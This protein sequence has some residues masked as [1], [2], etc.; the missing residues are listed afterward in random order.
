[1]LLAVAL[2]V[3]VAAGLLT[4]VAIPASALTYLGVAILAALESGLA[5]VRAGLDGTFDDRTFFLGFVT[6]TL[7]A[8]FI[9]YVGVSIGV[10][11]LYLAAV[12]AFGV[13]LFNDLAAVRDLLV[14]RM[15]WE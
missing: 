1:M 14:V 13:R 8:A 6:N 7:L 10:P 12:V 3:G 15:G 5:G 4:Q 11:E 9:V 2:A